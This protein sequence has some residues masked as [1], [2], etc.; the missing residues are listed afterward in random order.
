MQMN[1][2]WILEGLYILWNASRLSNDDVHNLFPK[3]LS[4]LVLCPAVHGSV[5]GGRGRGGRVGC[6]QLGMRSQVALATDQWLGS[7]L[8]AS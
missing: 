7:S 5:A 4:G 8:L 2:V 6:G 1:M 3:L